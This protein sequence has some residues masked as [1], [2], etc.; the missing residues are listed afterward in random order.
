MRGAVEDISERRKMID[1]S[2]M[3]HWKDEEV[4]ELLA[5]GGKEEIT[6]HWYSKRCH[7]L[8]QYCQNPNQPWDQTYI[9]AGGQQIEGTEKTIRRG[10]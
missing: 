5:I 8:H 1:S 10:P 3:A 6:D 4:K 2:K 7:S 9:A